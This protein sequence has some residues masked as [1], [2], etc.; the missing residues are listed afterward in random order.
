M[1][2]F[3]GV[4]LAVFFVFALSGFAQVNRPF[5]NGPVWAVSL[6]RVKA[7]MD[8]AYM[9]YV[10]NEWKKEQEALKTE[11]ISLG[12]KVLATEHHSS[13]DWNLMLMTEYKNLATLEASEQKADALA[14]RVVGSDEKQIQGYKER[15]D[16]REVMGTRLAREVI[17]EPA[18]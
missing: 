15:A 3:L 16:I 13:Q 5:H 14:Q 11:G 8:T 1:K 12:Y 17:L 18:P 4:V 6:I 10:A 2:K 7:G 9:N